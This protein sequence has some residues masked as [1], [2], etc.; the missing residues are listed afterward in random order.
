MDNYTPNSHKFRAEQKN[1]PAEERKKVEKVVSGKVKKKKAGP[2]LRDLFVPEDITD[3]RAFLIGDILI[4]AFKNM[5]LDTAEEFLDGGGSRRRKKRSRADQV[6]YRSYYR[7]ED[8]RDSRRSRTSYNYDEVYFDSR[9]DAEVVL[10]RMEEILDEYGQV[11]IADYYDLVGISGEY[12][13]NNYGWT[14]L[15]YAD[16]ER[17]R[18]GFTIKLPRV[19][20]LK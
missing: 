14:D 11:R 7:K 1:K 3:V 4:P 6:S 2:K 8:E 20:P 13:D 10:I 19:I 12:T 18:D 9:G 5:L 17:T 16:V 15:K